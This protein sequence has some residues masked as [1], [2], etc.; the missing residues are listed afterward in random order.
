MSQKMA[1]FVLDA[2]SRPQWFSLDVDE[3][4]IAE[5]QKHFA[6]H[7]W[8]V[9]PNFLHEDVA[10]RL[11]DYLLSHHML[12][13]WHSAVQSAGVPGTQY[14]L[15]VP[16]NAAKVV[17]NRAAANLRNPGCLCYSFFRSLKQGKETK[18]PALSQV[19]EL[20]SSDRLMK[21]IQKITD[22][23][24]SSVETIF[25]SRYVTGDFLDPHTDAA[26][27]TS[28]QLAFVINLSKN[29]DA[30]WG[31]NL[32]IDH[33]HTITPAFANLVLFDVRGPGRL[34]Y[35]SPVTDKTDETR[36]AVSGWLQA[37]PSGHCCAGQGNCQ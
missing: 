17:A 6:Q 16:K 30:A 12:G 25:A 31:G 20:M 8:V 28:R 14:V 22:L 15:D 18:N 4:K 10:E 11:R 27:G 23:P 32:V 26:P 21:A 19:F 35:V 24:V 5:A 36:V 37:D 2:P 7:R 34:H 9:I 13:E 33:V 1:D 29:W 3:A